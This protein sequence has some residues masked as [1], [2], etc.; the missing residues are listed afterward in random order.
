MALRS[1]HF[2]ST[3]L[4]QWV[5][6]SVH[7][8]IAELNNLASFLLDVRLV[9]F[10]GHLDDGGGL[11]WLLKHFLEVNLLDQQLLSFFGVQVVFRLNHQELLSRC[12][13]GR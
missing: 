13:L 2:L 7:Q 8:V 4:A 3:A 11:G 10:M 5:C 12:R 9:G 1:Q 6:E